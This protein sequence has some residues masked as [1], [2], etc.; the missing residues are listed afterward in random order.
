MEKYD[1]CITGGG[2]A[3]CAAA[4]IAG[5]LGLK[6]ILIEKN[7]Y[8]GGLMTGG[9]VVPA[10]K[11]D[12]SNINTEFYTDLIQCAKK[13][14]A[15]VEYKD[16]NKGW[17]NPN[18]L[19]I[20]LD[21]MLYKNNVDIMFEAEPINAIS[22]NKNLKKIEVGTRMLSLY[23]E[24]KYYLDSTG[25]SK[26][27]QLLNEDFYENNLK[28]QP[29]SLRFIMSG[30]NIKNLKDFLIKIDK[31]EEVTNF[32][33]NNG[34]IHLTSA[35]TWDDN[36]WNLKP[37]FNKG[38]KEGML[39][40]QDTAYFQIFTIAGAPTSIAFNCPRLEDFDPNNPIDYSKKLIYAR[41]SIYRIANFVKKYFK[42]F[43]NAYISQIADLT[44][45]RESNKIVSGKQV[46]IDDLLSEVKPENPVLSGDYPIDIH[47]NSK[48]SSVLKKMNKYY[49]EIESLKS[50]NYKNLYAA[51]RN[52]GADHKAQAALRV[53]ISCMSMGEAV[54]RDVKSK[55]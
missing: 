35:Y 44:G 19:K 36:G 30:V 3:G 47:S 41:K 39:E 7:N 14:N 34:E 31:N 51:G 9:L 52:L 48:N 42:G 50:A 5:K 11:T 24:A 38:I 43:E 4:Y 2:I 15:Q 6:T 29:A 49:I 26:I 40:I 21:E 18:L 8:L 28:K 13:Y 33:E 23:I 10:M 54:A 25:D 46:N 55:L 17:F 32:M 12:T 20:V 27:F 16:G 1:L 53:Q 45:I 37:L 22:E